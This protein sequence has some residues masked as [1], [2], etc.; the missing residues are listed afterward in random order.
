MSDYRLLHA[1][2]DGL[3]VAFQGRVD[4]H[5]L[6]ML[7]AAK[8]EAREQQ[9]NAH[10]AW[11]GL[12]FEVYPSGTSGY[13]FIVDTGPDGEIWMFQKTTDPSRW[14]IFVSV[15]AMGLAM[16]GLW[17]I[18][19][20]LWQRLEMFGAYVVDHSINRVDFAVDFEAPD[21]ALQPENI[22]AHWRST[23]SEYQPLEPQDAH[24]VRQ[25]RKVNSVTVGKMP[26][27]QVIIYDKRREVIDKRKKWWFE[28]WDVPPETQVWRLEVRAGKRY[29]KE[30]FDLTTFDDFDR[31]GGEVFEAILGDMDL[32]LEGQDDQNITRQA[33]HPFWTAAVE[34]ITARVVSTID[35]DAQEAVK[36]VWRDQKREQYEA[37]MGGLAASFSFVKG[38]GD[39]FD[40]L[41]I[42]AAV[43][44]AIAARIDQDRAKFISARKR[45][46]NRLRHMETEPWFEAGDL[47]GDAM[48]KGA[49]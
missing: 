46:A 11:R 48:P 15:K 32:K 24:I 7:E 13:S 22:V 9:T 41:T 30:K 40:P 10:R 39:D 4:P 42:G 8:A 18:K 44:G 2:Y 23:V 3:D 47:I 12:D 45:A 38:F 5:F 25:G 21:F 49:T 37:L 43:G 36:V 33:S 1:G 29:L 19:A 34:A 31:M 14:S 17:K 28:I 26:N 6:D 20:R 27:K 16:E 35:P